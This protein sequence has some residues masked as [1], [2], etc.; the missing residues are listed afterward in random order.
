MERES[1]LTWYSSLGDR[2]R[3]HT[4]GLPF[5]ASHL[6]FESPP[7]ASFDSCFYVA[8]AVSGPSDTFCVQLPTWQALDHSY[9]ERSNQLRRQATCPALSNYGETSRASGTVR[10]IDYRS[11]WSFTVGRGLLSPNDPP[12]S[13]YTGTIQ[14]PLLNQRYS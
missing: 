5:R 4:L 14:K 9:L 12:F 3:S 11:L 6:L 7:V 2:A 10:L 8:P 13:V 1:Y